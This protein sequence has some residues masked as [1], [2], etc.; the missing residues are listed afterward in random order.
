MTKLGTPKR[1]YMSA[2]ERADDGAGQ[3]GR[4]QGEHERPV[5]DVKPTPRIAAARPLTEPT[6]R[7]ISPSSSTSTMPSAIVPTAAHCSVRLTRL[8]GDR[9]AGVEAWNTVQMTTRPTTTG[10]RAEVAAAQPAGE[11]ATR[12]R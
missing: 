12:R 6:D 7:S 9:K 11:R 5:V 8:R 4:E 2:V 10:R 3:D 1:V